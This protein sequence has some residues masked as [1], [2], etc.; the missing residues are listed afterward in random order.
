MFRR[1]LIDTLAHAFH[2][3]SSSLSS[4]LVFSRRATSKIDPISGSLSIERQ[5]FVQACVG[6]ESGGEPAMIARF[7]G[8]VSA[9]ITNAGIASDICMHGTALVL[10]SGARAGAMML[11]AR[12]ALA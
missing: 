5:G 1:L 10:S 3:R 12:S 6:Y 7:A 9:W 11:T 8:E 4:F 2:I